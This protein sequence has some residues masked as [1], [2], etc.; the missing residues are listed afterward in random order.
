MSF[1]YFFAIAK[2]ELAIAIFHIKMNADYLAVTPI[3]TNGSH[4]FIKLVLP[5]LDE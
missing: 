1:G 4:R 3:F 5:T 2:K